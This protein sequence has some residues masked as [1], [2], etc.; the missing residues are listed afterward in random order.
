YPLPDALSWEESVLI[1]TAGTSVYG[2]DRAGGLVAG[3]TVVVFGP[4]PVGIMTAQTVRALGATSVIV[5]GTRQERLD[6]ATALGA[7]EVVNSTTHDP[8][9]EV[10]RLTDGRG[11]DMVI[12]SSG[13]PA[14]PNQG[15]EML[16]RG[17]K[18]LILA[19]YKDPVSF[20]LGFANREE[21]S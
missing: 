9:A 20:N 16:R 18:L 15:L 2:L 17:G 19:F 6:L 12:E 4:G 8:V 7:T 10:R 5:V 14:T 1:S 11:A 13:D 3:D 21:I